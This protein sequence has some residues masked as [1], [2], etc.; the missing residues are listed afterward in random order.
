MIDTSGGNVAYACLSLAENLGA[1]RIR[2]YGADFS[3]PKGRAYARGTYIYP[4]FERRQKRFLPS[5][6]QLYSFLA[7]DSSALQFYRKSFE[8]KVSKMEAE[9]TAA[10]GLGA[11]LTL[12][13]RR[14]SG[15]N[16]RIFSLFAP[17]KALMSAE[18]FLRQYRQEIAAL[19]IAGGMTHAER[20]V[21]LTLLPQAAALKRRNPGLS[22]AELLDAIK[23]YSTAEIDRVLQGYFS[24]TARSGRKSSAPFW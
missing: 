11:P 2:V 24:E 17:G 12:N 20:Q 22:N 14:F 3:Y 23:A 21:F 9:V 5:E 15:E 18:N 4:F 8:Q 13:P 16:K 19:P 7:R 10:P 6:T 1:Q